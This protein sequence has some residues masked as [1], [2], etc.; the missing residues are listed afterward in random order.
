MANS[1]GFIR[2]NYSV[3]FARGYHALGIYYQETA[4]YDS[5][6]HFQLTALRLFKKQNN[7]TFQ[8]A[9]LNNICNIYKGTAQYGKAI[10]YGIQSMKLADESN[11][12]RARVYARTNTGESYHLMGDVKNAQPLYEEAY[13]IAEENNEEEL[14]ADASV[15]LGNLFLGKGDLDS[16][17]KEYLRAYDINVKLKRY[18]DI[19][20]LLSNIGAVHFYKGD[21]KKALEY[22]QVALGYAKQLKNQQQE[23]IGKLNIGEAYGE[24][25][26]YTLGDLYLDSA[27]ALG[28]KIKSKNFVSSAYAM[29]KGFYEKQG[30]MASALKSLELSHIYKDSIINEANN[31]HV[32]EL[33][34]GYQ[35]EKRSKEIESLKQRDAIQQL[36]ISRQRLYFGAS[37]VILLLIGFS[38]WQFQRSRRYKEKM[39]HETKLKE[40]QDKAAHAIIETELNERRRIAAELHDGVVQTFSAAKMNLSGITGSINFYNQSHQKVYENTMTMIDEGCN[41]LRSIS[42]TM[43]PEVLLKK[44]LTEALRELVNRIDQK[45]ININLGVYGLHQRLS[46]GIETSV[47]RIVQES[48]NNTLKH[49]NATSMDIQLSLD[50][51][52]LH[53]TIED[54]GK[55]FDTTQ[56]KKDGIGLRN[57]T[58]RVNLLLGKIDIDSSEGKGTLLAISFPVGK[59]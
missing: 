1:F 14:M 9:S 53:L 3:A 7:P 20:G 31:R 43:M 46:A 21:L 16:G 22:Y 35:A 5:A 41:E 15:Y 24:I 42:H 54:N 48:L 34:E 25:K 18:I 19:D 40:E 2:L 57:I 39:L 12:T 59:K 58:S 52:H 29:K 36:S 47:Y 28:K 30:N 13:K 32:A 11:N 4:K 27:I 10:E 51:D 50:D 44:G 26:N 8:A 38:A 6:L 55:G 56:V 23:V 45:S 49:A 17:L 37:A 33:Q